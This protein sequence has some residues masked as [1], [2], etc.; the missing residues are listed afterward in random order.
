MTRMKK[1]AEVARLRARGDLT[2]TEI[3]RRMGISRQYVSALLHDPDGA[4][5]RKR[6]SSYTC[7][8]CGGNRDRKAK[9]CEECDMAI[10]HE[11]KTW[12]RESVIAAI[13]RFAAEHG[14]PPTA[15]DWKHAD[16][17]YGYPGTSTVYGKPPWKPFAAW[18]DAIEAA[19]FPRPL[20]GRRAVCLP[21]D[22]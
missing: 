21:G 22:F 1:A 11:K 19:G 9:V 18:G 14:R 6:E 4:K 2:L 8:R 16:P 13:Q 10:R 17:E 7:G 20:S 12:T 5:Q 3:A 15:S